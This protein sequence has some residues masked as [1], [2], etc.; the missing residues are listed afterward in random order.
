[1]RYLLEGDVRR[2]G[3]K[4]RVNVQLTDAS[5]R[6]N[7]W[8]E[9]YDGDYANLFDLQ[10]RLVG[11]VVEALSVRLTESETIQ[12][13]RLPTR[14]LEAYDYYTR[15]EQ[16]AFIAD[17]RSLREALALYEKAISLD[18]TFSDAYAGYARASVDVLGFDYQPVMLSVIA[19][20]R[21]Y[22]AA[23]RALEL[24]PKTS[25]AHSVLGI[26]QMLDREFDRAIESVRTAEKLDPN[27][28]T[29]SSTWRSC[30]PMQG[31]M[32]KRC[33]PWSNCS[34]R[35]QTTAAGFG[36][37]GPRALHEPPLRGCG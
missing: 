21:A 10:D 26:L 23:G 17:F 8:A 29:P 36:L 9:R 28:A 1:V 27:G 20:Q 11:K 19:R 33:P 16:K 34:T 13:A 18:P 25:R 6:A 4:V 35:S 12:I 15:A 2:S 22:D 24:N 30:S 3:N 14:N 37:S 7:L 5:T 32:R 31:R